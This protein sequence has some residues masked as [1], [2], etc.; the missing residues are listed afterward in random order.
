MNALDSRLLGG[1]VIEAAVAVLP[2]VERRAV[3]EPEIVADQVLRDVGGDGR[4]EVEGGK[5]DAG[6]QAGR[7]PHP[8]PLAEV[9]DQGRQKIR[10][11]PSG[12]ALSGFL[13]S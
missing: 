5:Q 10:A 7:G 2:T 12:A 9:H 3:D 6:P 4:I 13:V 1:K 8:G 11:A